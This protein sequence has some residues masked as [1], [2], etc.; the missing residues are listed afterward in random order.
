M[1][2]LGYSV[3][4]NPLTIAAGAPGATVGSNPNEGAAYLFGR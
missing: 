3:S 4:A 1:D 2:G